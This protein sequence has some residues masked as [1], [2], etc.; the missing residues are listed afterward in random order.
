MNWEQGTDIEYIVTYDDGIVDSWDWLS[1]GHTDSYGAMTT[2]TSHTYAKHG[3]YTITV[4]ITNDL[5][6]NVY[7]VELV[8]EATLEDVMV[9]EVSTIASPTPNPTN[10]SITPTLAP[11]F[12]DI[13]M[14]CTFTFDDPA[15]PTSNQH[16]YI[17]LGD[18]RPW[19][20]MHTFMTDKPSAQL[21]IVC[22]NHFSKTT[23][24]TFII[25]QQPISGLEIFPKELAV[26]S[27]M[28]AHYTI[29]TK[30]GSHLTY[31]VDHG[32]GLSM[33][34]TDPNRL[35]YKSDF[36]ANHTYTTVGIYTMSV[37]AENVFYN[38][39]SYSTTQI[40]VQNSVANLQFVFPQIVAWPPGQ[41]HSQ[42]IPD[43]ASPHPTN[44]TCI[45]YAEDTTLY[46]AVTPELSTG[47]TYKT[48][49]QF[50]YSHIGY[51]LT[52]SINCSNL[53]SNQ[54][55]VDIIVMYEIISG[56]FVDS[57]HKATMPNSAFNL[58]ISMTAG[59]NVDYNIDY[60]LN[61]IGYAHPGIFA[62]VYSLVISYSYPS[63]GN[64]TITVFAYN[65]VSNESY[66][67]PYELIVQH[68]ITNLSLWA[69][70]P[71]LY[72]PGTV[73]Y[74]ITVGLPQMPLTHVHCHWDVNGTSLSNQ[75]FPMMSPGD[76][77]E[78]KHSFDRS[79]IG[80]IITTI[81]CSNLISHYSI[82]ARTNIILDAVILE[83]LNSNGT[84]FVTNT[85]VLILNISRFGSKSCFHWD[86]GDGKFETVYGLALCEKYASNKGINFTEIP[87]GQMQ[88]IQEYVYDH[89]DLFPVTVFAFNHVSND[90]AT[91]IATVRDWYCY[92][93][94]ITLNATYTV[95]SHPLQHMKSVQLYIKSVLSVDCMKTSVV[96]H[97][98]TVFTVASSSTPLLTQTGDQWFDYQP[99][100]LPYGQY[101]I[102][103]TISMHN[104]LSTTQYE[105]AYLEIIK[106]PLKLVLKGQGS[107]E[108][109]TYGS[110]FMINATEGVV[111]PDVESSDKSGFTYTL[112]CQQNGTIINPALLNPDNVGPDMK[113][114]FDN[115]NGCLG[116]KPGII[117]SSVIG[118][119]TIDTVLLLPFS[120]YKFTVEASKDTRK[121]SVSQLTYIPPL[122][123]PV[124]SIR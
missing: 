15:S 28:V 75:Y 13:S 114:V 74:V 61:P 12:Q 9:F 30:A 39:S 77:I 88:I 64:Y 83:S 118:L 113:K 48:N 51:N 100:D 58:T 50:L 85:S 18:D 56:L 72:T 49:I 53:V 104:I 1:E 98:W 94:N 36:K 31:T 19:T 79:Y 14:W 55:F 6:S 27:Y 5:G 35:S 122:E 78:D 120:W 32:D 105:M 91:T 87:F 25:L 101:Q 59:S 102:N 23:Y 70:D 41:L 97:M 62:S 43:S 22:E 40:T 108:N 7:T 60:N 121:T 81:N 106:S 17:Q 112:A 4:N 107:I 73:E 57:S 84:V 96:D 33:S 21:D 26:P 63:T 46:Q 92:Q 86:M 110:E 117:S 42:I 2:Y 20:M 82:H 44:V 109:I 3:N 115:I 95:D 66:S 37:F 68:P 123:A 93:P 54:T 47:Q 52:L 11:P 29:V 99:R 8:V 24:Q 80:E 67:L 71:V 89:Y 69:N 65:P 119:F 16:L 124:I 90:S 103:Y 76:I 10:I 34:Y 45:W 111:D 116:N 38:L